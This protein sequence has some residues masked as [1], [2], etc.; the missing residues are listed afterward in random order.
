MSAGT[1]DDADVQYRGVCDNCPN[2]FLFTGDFGDGSHTLITGV[3][4]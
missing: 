2:P 3:I 1:T 4:A